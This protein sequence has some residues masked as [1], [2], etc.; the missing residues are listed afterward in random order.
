MAPAVLPYRCEYVTDWAA[1]NGR[2]QLCTGPD[3]QDARSRLSLTG[4][5]CCVKLMSDVAFPSSRP[6][7]PL[8]DC[9][10]CGPEP[11]WAGH[12]DAVAQGL[13]GK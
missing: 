2:Y 13:H 9:P 11:A 7:P 8:G 12:A 3:E 10:T 5:T 6:G 4:H 1:G